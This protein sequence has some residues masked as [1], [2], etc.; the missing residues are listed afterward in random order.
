MDPHVEAQK[1]GFHCTG[2]PLGQR[3]FRRYDSAGRQGTMKDG[4]VPEAKQLRR[5]SR[6][7]WIGKFVRRKSETS[8]TES[9]LRTG[10]SCPSV[11][12][13]NAVH[14]L[15]RQ[16]ACS[17]CH[18]QLFRPSWQL[19]AIRYTGRHS[20]RLQRGHTPGGARKAQS[21]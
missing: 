8:A 10:G 14:R 5:L 17:L 18:C 4:N 12:H 7:D 9:V 19:L 16:L 3:P 11:R 15:P 6:S 1:A 13:S 20:G 21:V 2:P